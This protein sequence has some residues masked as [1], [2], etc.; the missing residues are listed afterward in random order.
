MDSTGIMGQ[1]LVTVAVFVVLLAMLPLAVKWVQR[2]TGGGAS[3]ALAGS[4]LVSALAV[5]PQQRVLTVEVGPEGARTWLILGVTGQ[6]ITCL[7]SMPAGPQRAAAAAAAPA[8][9][10]VEPVFHADMQGQN[11]G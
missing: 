7:H 1:T 3:A 5:G 11:R 6:T 4:R 10:L 8:M 2:R 9:A